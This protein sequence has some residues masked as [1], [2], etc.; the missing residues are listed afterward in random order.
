MIDV[1]KGGKRLKGERERKGREI[2]RRKGK[3]RG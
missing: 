1:R 3:S 2:T